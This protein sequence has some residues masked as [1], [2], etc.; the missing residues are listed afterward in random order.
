MSSDIARN[1]DLGWKAVQ[2]G[3][4]DG[5]AEGGDRATGLVDTLANLLHWADC[6][7]VDFSAALTSAEAHHA[8]EVAGE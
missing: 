2:G 7:G 8:A 5:N 4:P 1:V 3:D 6:Y